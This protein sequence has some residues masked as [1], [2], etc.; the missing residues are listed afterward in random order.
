MSETAVRKRIRRLTRDG[1]IQFIT[2][3]NPSA[4]GYAVDVMFTIKAKSGQTEAIARALESRH[5]V[6]WLSVITGPQEIMG[7]VVLK[8]DDELYEFLHGF[9]SGVEGIMWVETF[10]I[11]KNVK[12]NYEWRPQD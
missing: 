1:V 12:F 6:V 11:L 3:V 2:V 8:D 7:E 4:V 5:Q 10:R 9:L